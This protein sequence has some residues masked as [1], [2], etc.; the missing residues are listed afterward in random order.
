MKTLPLVSIIIP[1]RNEEKTLPR[2]LESLLNQTY[3]NKE[4]IVVD[5]QSTD[6]TAEIVKIAVEKDPTLKL[7]QVSNKPQ[8]WVGKNYALFQ[9]AA[10]ANGD[11]YLFIDADVTLSP[12]CIE[13][14]M[15]SMLE[16]DLDMMS[17]AAFQ[18]C[19]TFWEKAVQP[20]VFLLLNLLF[21][22]SK[23]NDPNASEAAFN[24]IF[25]LSTAMAYKK[26]GTHEVVKSSVLEDVELA[27]K[28]KALSLKTQF[29][30][31][32]S[33]IRVRM[34][35]S[36]EDIW[37]GWGKNLFA[38]LNFSYLK[39]TA[40]IM[41]PVLFWGAVILA[42]WFSVMGIFLLLPLFSLWILVLYG[43]G[44]MG[45]HASIAAFFPVG[46]IVLA[47]IALYSVFQY[48][49]K[50]TVQWKNR[51]YPVNPSI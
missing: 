38:L 2:C 36:L 27:K 34:Y 14:S 41:L 33:L 21:P 25:I 6:R 45:Y 30:Y 51:S 37:E 43:Y 32:P 15:T 50:G 42:F 5:D 26:I 22:L 7:I 49:V 48:S 44:K 10:V 4:I 9:G 20:L 35:T 11:Y 13:H 18:E 3:P 47:L 29:V 46:C 19:L 8:D 17:Y 1:A 28:A 12:Y 23:V 24:G 40:V 16:N 39:A 31:R